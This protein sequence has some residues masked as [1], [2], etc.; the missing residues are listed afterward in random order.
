M[1]GPAH[2]VFAPACEPGSWQ[3]LTAAAS[4]RSTMLYV[5]RFLTFSEVSRLIASGKN[6]RVVV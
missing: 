4:Y 5:A 2:G 3:T 1:R 6:E